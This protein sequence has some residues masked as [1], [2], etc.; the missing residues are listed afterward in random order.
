MKNKSIEEAK[1]KA[2]YSAVD[3]FI[4]DG[5]VVG[6]GSGSTVVYAVERIVERVKKENL[7]L[8]CIPTSFQSYQLITLNNLTLG[9]LDNYPEIDVDIDGADEIDKD[10]NLIKG[11]GGCHVQEKIIASNSKKMVVIA[12]YRKDSSKLGEKWKKGVPVEVIPLAYIPIMKKLEKI[13]GKPVLRMAKSKAGPCVSDNGNFIIDVDFGVIENPIDLNFKIK[14]IPGVVDT[15]F[16][17]NTQDANIVMA[18][19][20]LENGDI[21]KIIKK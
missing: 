12:D 9:S 19:I 6:I 5:M 7:K 2:G 17:I 1:K 16:F 13:G 21:K 15:G 18:Y 3:D 10:L 14:K 20:G 8:V 4:K 11:G